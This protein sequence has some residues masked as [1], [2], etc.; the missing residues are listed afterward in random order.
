MGVH[1]EWL[2]FN[3]HNIHGPCVV[4]KSTLPFS[5]GPGRKKDMIYPIS[6]EQHRVERSR[7]PAES[8]HAVRLHGGFRT[9]LA[10]Q[11]PWVDGHD[12]WKKARRRSSV[13]MSAHDGFII[14]TRYYHTILHLQTST[15]ADAGI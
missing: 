12:P 6:A 5:S 4:R 15:S 10:L 11:D 8:M 3:I 7:W 1:F 9:C 13:M 14:P 2:L